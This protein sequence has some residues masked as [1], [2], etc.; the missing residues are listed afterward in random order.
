MRFEASSEFDV[1]A[2]PHK[3]QRLQ[4]ETPLELTAG[5]HTSRDPRH[6]FGILWRDLASM[7]S[8]LHE[9][10][11]SKASFRTCSKVHL[12]RNRPLDTTGSRCGFA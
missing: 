6:D 5:F 4:L 1:N 10:Q 9:L 7:L 12:L 11:P 2:W 3:I 8:E